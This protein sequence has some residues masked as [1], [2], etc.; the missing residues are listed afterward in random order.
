M[1]NNIIEY[2][3][4]RLDAW[5]TN[6]NKDYGVIGSAKMSLKSEDKEKKVFIIKSEE[7]GEKE[8]REYTLYKSENDSIHYIFDM[9][10]AGE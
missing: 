4:R 10:S 5:Y 3:N 2:T 8:E 6:V 1:L 7:D 9:W